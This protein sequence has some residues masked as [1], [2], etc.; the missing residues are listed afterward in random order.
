MQ[1]RSACTRVASTTSAT[2]PLGHNVDHTA[3][4]TLALQVEWWPLGPTGLLY[5][6][7]WALLG[8]DSAVVTQK[9]YPRLALVQVRCLL[10]GVA[11][12]V[13]LG[14]AA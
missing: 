9:Q 6:R 7:E 3:S 14:G 5:D 12:D 8:D 13:P 11:G 4:M 2:K 1:A 10:V